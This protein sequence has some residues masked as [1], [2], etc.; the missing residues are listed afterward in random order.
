MRYAVNGFARP[1]R[2]PAV[3]ARRHALG[4]GFTLVEL[5]VVIAII[6]TL[7]G[8]L[9]PAVQ[10]ARESAR[11]SQCKNNLRQ[12]GVAVHSYQSAKKKFPAGGVPSPTDGW[13]HSWLV[14]SLPFLEETAIYNKLDLKGE[15][16]TGG[17]T[18]LLFS[19]DGNVYNSKLLAGVPMPMLSCPS[20]TLERFVMQGSI[21]GTPAGVIS[22][23][24]TG[25]A[26]AGVPTHY[27]D[28]NGTPVDGVGW[29]SR[30][31]VLISETA[32]GTK[33]IPDGL[34]KTIMVG[35]QSDW[36]RTMTSGREDCRSDFNAGFAMGPCKGGYGP[37][38]D[39]KGNRAGGGRH[40]NMTTIRHEVNDK[41][42]ENW[43]V[44]DPFGQ[45][46]PIQ[47]AHRAGAHVLMADGSA[48][49]LAAE[50]AKTSVLFPLCVR[51][52]GRS[53]SLP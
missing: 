7:I 13:G 5:L 29:V 19:P 18:G 22:T 4:A 49:M 28:Q 3:P 40:F 51:N 52:D 24:Y 48:H 35:E 12:I 47:S 21:E 30:S 37:K 33:D 6:A 32:I 15:Q 17:Y 10:S 45:N 2:S 41:T 34:S 23:M 36:C 16:S 38:N 50:T 53:V 46:R 43:A 27:W 25:I 26:G 44:S 1:G 42:W 11:M 39:G 9:L 8:L 31:G 20:S 14:L